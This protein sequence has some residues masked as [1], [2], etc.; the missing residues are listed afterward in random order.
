MGSWRLL[1][2][3]N[4]NEGG[5][6]R[7]YRGPRQRQHDPFLP[8]QLSANQRGNWQHQSQRNP[9]DREPTIIHQ[10]TISRPSN[11][12][13]TPG[14]TSSCKVGIIQALVE[15]RKHSRPGAASNPKF[16]RHG[17]MC[18]CRMRLAAKAIGHEDI[19]A[20][21]QL[22]HIICYSTEISSISDRLAIGFEAV[23][24]GFGR[25]MRHLAPTHAETRMHPQAVE[26][27]EADDRRIAVLPRQRHS[28]TAGAAEGRFPRM[29]SPAAARHGRSASPADHRSRGSDRHGHESRK[30]H[31]PYRCHLPSNCW[32]RSVEVSTSSLEPDHFR[33]GSKREYGGSS[34]RRDRIRPSHCRF[35]ERLSTCLSQAQAASL[36][37]FLEQIVKIPGCR[38]RQA[39]DTLP[40]QLRNECRRIR[41]IGRFAGF[42]A[43]RHR[44]EKRTIGF[45]Q[46]SVCRQTGCNFLQ[47]LGILERDNTRQ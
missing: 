38:S 23:S 31:R 7:K 24:S 32:R 8:L 11:P 44:C 47:F 33:R 35:A 16:Q 37:C 15:M 10:A 2:V 17:K 36:R 26:H 34:V 43:M 39:L 1:P 45:H 12:T 22:D 13:I 46:H 4:R 27:F 9:D 19:D 41:D 25:T 21:Q 30:R 18:M 14:G 6:H 20:F 29:Q 42:S 3:H 40:A 28:R 5:C